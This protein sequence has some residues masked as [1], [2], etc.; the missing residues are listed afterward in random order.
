MSTSSSPETTAIAG[1]GWRRPTVSIV[2]RGAGRAMRFG[3][4]R[5]AASRRSEVSSTCRRRSRSPR[6]SYSR[7]VASCFAPSPP[8]TGS[9]PSGRISAPSTLRQPASLVSSGCTGRTTAG[10]VSA[11][12]RPQSSGMRPATSGN[13]ERQP[14]VSLNRLAADGLSIILAIL[15]CVPL[16]GEPR[17]SAR[18]RLTRSLPYEMLLIQLWLALTYRLVNKCP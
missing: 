14:L 1:S 3:S 17:T 7:I 8:G 12:R 4:T 2:A 5:R 16:T 11:L 10:A 6:T 9:S 15:W 18:N 13:A